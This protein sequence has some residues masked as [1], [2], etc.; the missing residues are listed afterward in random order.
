MKG[1]FGAIADSLFLC[2]FASLRDIFLR[3]LL[4]SLRVLGVVWELPLSPLAGSN[5]CEGALDVSC[6]GYSRLTS[7]RKDTKVTKTGERS[8]RWEQLFRGR[9]R[10]RLGWVLA[11]RRYADAPIR[12]YVLLGC[13]PED[14]EEMAGGSGGDE[15]MPNEMAIT[16]LFGQVKGNA[17]GVSEAAG[18]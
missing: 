16:E 4:Q 3:S 15:E 18:G 11:A 5:G 1:F 12:R 14:G 17:A 8:A 10:V 2:G 9:G 7:H 6:A 13:V